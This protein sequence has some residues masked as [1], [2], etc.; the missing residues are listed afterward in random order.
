MRSNQPRIQLAAAPLFQEFLAL[1]LLGL[2]QAQHLPFQRGLA[3]VQALELVDQL[4]DAVVVEMHLLHKPHQFLALLLIGLLGTLRVLAAG[5]I[6]IHPLR[7]ELLQLAEQALDLFE[8][9]QRFRLQLFFQS[10]EREAHALGGLVAFLIFLLGRRCA[11]R[12]IRAGRRLQVDDIPQKHAAFLDRVVPGDDRLEGQGAFA[13]PPDHHV[14]AGLDALGDG[15][16]ALAGQQFDAAHLAQI[17]ADRVVGAAEIGLIDIAAAFLVVLVVFLGLGG[18][19]G[20]GLAILRFLGFD[21]IDAE[22]VERRHRVLDEF[23]GHLLGRQGGVQFV[24]G[25]VAAF[26]AA[27]DQLL[28][29]GRQGVEQH[30]FHRFVAPIRRVGA[31]RGLARHAFSRSVKGALARPGLGPAFACANSPRPAPPR[32]TSP[33]FSAG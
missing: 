3:A 13:Q 25:D 15:D 19:L 6:G 4:L 14:A 32:A 26:L 20:R 29:R 5:R 16:L 24:I 7:R 21:D 33:P 8:G 28:D 30:A 10:G 23:G 11:F 27:G 22:L 31:I 12:G 9:D 17:H 1:D 18:L 2:G